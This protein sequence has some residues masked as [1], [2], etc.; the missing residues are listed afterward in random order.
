[1][2]S[3]RR[4]AC[5]KAQDHADFQKGLQ[6]GFT[7]GGIGSDRQFCVATTI[8]TGFG[9]KAG[10]QPCLSDVRFTPESGHSLIVVDDMARSSI[11][12][13][14]EAEIGSYTGFG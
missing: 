3:R 8:R 5:P 2:K 1:M 4:I 6:Q 9:S 7:T 12:R 11:G 13:H 10:I 14:M